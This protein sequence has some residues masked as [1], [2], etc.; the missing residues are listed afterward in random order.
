VRS[1]VAMFW[2]RRSPRP[3][4]LGHRPARGHAA[5]GAARDIA[6]VVA[7]CVRTGIDFEESWLDPFTSSVSHRADQIKAA[8]SRV[9]NELRQ[10]IE[11]GMSL[12][13]ETTSSTRRYVDSSIER[14][15]ITVTW[16]LD[17]HL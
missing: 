17:R 12:G 14:V 10:A 4:S 3:W 2:D 6:A 13:E 16:R 7:I 9:W 1:L 11:P 5:Q 8:G 15:Q